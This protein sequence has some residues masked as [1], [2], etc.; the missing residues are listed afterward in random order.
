MEIVHVSHE[1]HETRWEYD[2]GSYGNIPTTLSAYRALNKGYI[3]T[4]S[5]IVPII[6]RCL[7]K[8]LRLR[9]VVNAGSQQ[10][11]WPRVPGAYFR[12][13]FNNDSFRVACEI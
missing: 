3:L 7:G 1:R 10:G 4:Y 5:K 6:Q 13:C 12:T 11:T 9:T 8:F 2:D